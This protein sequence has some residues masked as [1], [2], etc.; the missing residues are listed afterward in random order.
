MI[1]IKLRG[2]LGNQMF[3]YAFGRA[4]ADK[5]HT[6]LALDP[7]A[8]DLPTYALGNTPRT[9]KLN[10]F[11]IQAQVITVEQAHTFNTVPRKI[12]Q[13]IQ[14]I[15]FRENS[16]KFSPGYLCMRDG[17]YAIGYW[18]SEKYFASVKDAIRK[19]FVLKQPFGPAAEK[20]LQEIKSKP[21]SV[22]LSIRRTDYLKDPTFKD[23]VCTQEYY[24]RAL[25]H[26][27]STLNMDVS[28]L[29]VFIT[30]DDKA[31]ADTLKLPC[32]YSF[33]SEND[34][35][36]YEWMMLIAQCSHH[37]I[38]NSTFSWWGAW[39]NSKPNKIVVA[40]KNWAALN[41]PTPD[42]IPESWVTL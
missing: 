22:S 24:L 16:W 17:S 30:T 12:I 7:H 11:N 4:L 28:K 21:I 9:Y 29:H 23:V 34:A 18:Q 27:A 25:D 32:P 26:I 41:I 2:G 15:L 40:P 1:T 6:T 38:A 31:W 39:L 8:Y 13:K 42:I 19:E 5:L 10:A 33:I 20:V 37:I 36:D 14:H 35:Q 3:Q